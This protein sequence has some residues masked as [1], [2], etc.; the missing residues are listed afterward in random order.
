MNSYIK[1]VNTIKIFGTVVLTALMLPP[2]LSGKTYAMHSNSNFNQLSSR[3]DEKQVLLEKL[4]GKIRDFLYNF[5]IVCNRS[6]NSA[7]GI[8]IFGRYLW[9]T[10]NKKAQ[11]ARKESCQSD[12]SLNFDK[13]RA[14]YNEAFVAEWRPGGKA[15]NHVK[16]KN[17]E[18]FR[19]LT[20]TIDECVE[21]LKKTWT[22]RIAKNLYYI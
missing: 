1:K 15:Y 18:Y 2:T 6:L 8:K 4:P 17:V 22:S 20:N 13:Y 7:D 21:S 9:D 12:N 10:V 14:T 19:D 3:I 5:N 11:E 16:D